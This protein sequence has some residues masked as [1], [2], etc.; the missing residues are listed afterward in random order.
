MR[1]TGYEIQMGGRNFVGVS[2]LIESSIGWSTL[3]CCFKVI[4]ILN[5][6]CLSNFVPK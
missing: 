6:K 3:L 4:R 1:D 5:Q 2:S